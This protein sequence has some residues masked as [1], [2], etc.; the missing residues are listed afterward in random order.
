MIVSSSIEVYTTVMSWHVHNGIWELLAGTGIALIPFAG[1][2]IKNLIEARKSQDKADI[3]VLAFRLSEIEL[4]V[5]IFV[6][7]LFINPAINLAPH[8]VTARVQHCEFQGNTVTKEIRALS[9]GNTGT[10]YDRVDSLQLGSSQT[11]K[12]PLMW[13]VWDYLAQAFTLAAKASLPCQPDLRRISTGVAVARIDDAQLRD[14]T[15]SFYRDC[16]RP[17]YNRY[18]RDKPIDPRDPSMSRI[19]QDVRWAGSQFFLNHQSYYGSYRTR[20]ALQSFPYKESRDDRIVKPQYSDGRGWPKCKEWWEDEA[21]GLKSRLLD[22]FHDQLGGNEPQS[23]WSAFMQLLGRSNQNDPDTALR[24]ILMTDTDMQLLQANNSY[25]REGSG[26]AMSRIGDNAASGAAGIMSWVGGDRAKARMYRDAAPVIQAITLMAITLSTPILLVVS[27]YSLKPLVTLLLVKFS[28][29][30]WGF[31]FAL[32]TWL[33][34]YLLFAL[35]WTPDN[36]NYRSFLGINNNSGSYSMT[37]QAIEY[38][39]RALF[40]VLPVTFSWLM[41]TVGLNVG[42]AAGTIQSAGSGAAAGANPAAAANAVKGM[43]R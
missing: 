29:I 26:G 33:D 24:E 10:T 13:Y 16:W 12:V 14:E 2:I 8:S 30:F 17:S 21:Y 39:T 18:L 25:P 27:G 22:H 38:V 7:V 43:K 40:I 37:V 11:P 20:E 1:I 15:A 34:N 42:E 41:M 9:H 36:V 19:D 31:L 4:Y 32:A 28:V 35:Q 5:A 6:V 3:G 23:T